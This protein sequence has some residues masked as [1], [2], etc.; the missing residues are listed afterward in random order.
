[1]E[2]KLIELQ[3]E[4]QTNRQHIEVLLST[5]PRPTPSTINSKLKKSQR[6]EGQISNLRDFIANP[7]LV[8]ELVRFKHTQS[9]SLFF[10]QFGHVKKIPTALTV[11]ITDDRDNVHLRFI[12]TIQRMNE[13]EDGHHHD[14]DDNNGDDDDGNHGD[15]DDDDDDGDDDDYDGDNDDP[16]D[17]DSDDEDD[18]T[19]TEDSIGDDGDNDHADNDDDSDHDDNDHDDDAR[20]YCNYVV[21]YDS[22]RDSPY[23]YVCDDY[24]PWYRY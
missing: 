7:I 11:E 17:D 15:D 20:S 8:G 3:A 22:E 12:H 23:D 18:D 10:D 24:Y 19:V 14:G 2:Q 1:M 4:L 5:V 16:D 6:L 13:H 21:E 9:H